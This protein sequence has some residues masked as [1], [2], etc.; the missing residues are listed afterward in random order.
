MLNFTPS[1]LE[2]D[3]TL[4]HTGCIGWQLVTHVYIVR[5]KVLYLYELGLLLH[6]HSHTHM[7]IP[8]YRHTD[9]QT[10]NSVRIM[11]L[12]LSAKLPLLFLSC[13]DVPT[14]RKSSYWECLLAQKLLLPF[15]YLPLAWFLAFLENR[16]LSVLEKE[17]ENH[18][19]ILASHVSWNGKVLGFASYW[20]MQLTV[21]SLD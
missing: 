1:S 15:L 10:P 12:T 19:L 20:V 8:V 18:H 4:Q 7:H 11:A 17:G 2:Q 13:T 14:P 5:K 6:L 21:F 16:E 9:A 3:L